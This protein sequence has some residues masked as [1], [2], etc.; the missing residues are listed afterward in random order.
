MRGTQCTSRERIPILPCFSL[1][2]PHASGCPRLPVAPA[3]N[4][5][6][7]F[8]S[9]TFDLGEELQGPSL[10]PETAVEHVRSR[11]E[12]VRSVVVSGPGAPHAN[13]ATFVVLRQL[14]CLF[15]E[16]L[17]GISTNGLLL[18]DRLEQVVADGVRNIA[19]TI[20]SFWPETAKR[21]YS[22]ILYKGRRYSQGG[23][24]GIPA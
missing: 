16:L 15:P 12:R 18:R 17:L 3:S 22:R 23:R 4:I 14:N 10:T 7:D 6:C 24:G 11:I 13:A 5:Q 19:I 20:S 1:D 2:D 9:R 21:A 8:C